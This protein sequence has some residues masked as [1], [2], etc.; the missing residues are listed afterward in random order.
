MDVCQRLVPC[1]QDEIC[2][3]TVVRSEG[4][5]CVSGEMGE[6][7]TV[8]V[9]TGGAKVTSQLDGLVN[10]YIEVSIYDEAIEY[11]RCCNSI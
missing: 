6:G 7:V 5:V 8:S 4:Y 3:E 1:Q 2:L 10:E 9:E 11:E